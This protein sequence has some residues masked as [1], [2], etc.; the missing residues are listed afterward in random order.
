MSNQMGV[1]LDEP[2]RAV[3]ESFDKTG[4]FGTTGYLVDESGA[5]RPTVTRRLD[6]L[7]A[8]GHIEYVHKPTAFWSL[9][10]D[11]RDAEEDSGA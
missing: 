3:L 5:S 2:T 4:G 11:P 6:R 7:K 1:R 10:D 8:A 9:I